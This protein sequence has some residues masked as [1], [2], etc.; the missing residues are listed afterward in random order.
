[1]FP[2]LKLDYF[3]NN[4]KKII[5]RVINSPIE[6][7]EAVLL[8][9]TDKLSTIR[10]KLEKNYKQ[11][12]F[13]NKF[14]ENDDTS[15]K[16][17]E[18]KSEFEEQFCLENIIDDKNILYIKYDIVTNID[19]SFFINKCQL[20]YG[21]TMTS[22]KIKKADKRAFEIKNSELKEI[23]S[24]GYE[25]N[26]IKFK[27][28]EERMKITNLIFTA[29]IDVDNFV[30]LGMSIGNKENKKSNSETSGSYYFIKHAKA[31]LKFNHN[32]TQE[33]IEEVETAIESE[34]PAEKLRQITDK[35]GQ[36][37]PTEVILGGRVY[38]DEQITSNR[39]L[40]ENS[41]EISVNAKAGVV[42]QTSVTNASNNSEGMSDYQESNYIELVGGEPVNSLF[43]EKDWV[44]SLKNYNYWDCIE[45]RSLISI[46]Q[47]LTYELRK[48]IITSV[49]KRIL[50]SAI[51]E[52]K[53][54]LETHG[55]AKNHVL[56]K[57]PQNILKMIHNKDAECNIFATVTDM[58]ELKKDLFTCQV[59]YPPN[60]KP[61]LLIHCI[62]EK[63]KKRECKLKIKWMVIGYY[64][65]FNLILSDLNVQSVKIF[66]N[67]ITSDNRTIIST[68]NF[69]YDPCDREVPPCFGIPV[70]TEK[71]SSN[72]SVVIGHHFFDAQEENKI[73]AC[74]FS[75]CSKNGRYICLPNFT[76]YTF[77]ISESCKNYTYYINSFEHP[78]ITRKKPY[79]N[80]NNDFTESSPK[81]ISLYSTQKTNYGP[82]FLK[83]NC[84]KIKLK[85]VN[86]KTNTIEQLKASK[87][88]IKCL[89][90]D[91]YISDN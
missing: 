42:L 76:F 35:F 62:Q 15:Y 10:E 29:D 64:T 52:L 8:N 78:F 26:K 32:P 85:F 4:D 75:Y 77:V 13:L 86:C 31:S 88:D 60:G 44:E 16:F 33:F 9:P 30:K 17:A 72:N 82:A 20:N 61:S 28:T 54:S 14:S 39:Y 49:G 3:G 43:N 12:N 66:E 41:R 89:C 1:M 25:K 74:M 18:I 36:F 34:D 70:L 50:Y 23:G 46:F 73:G 24:E 48:K 68:L 19:R 57:I 65:D 79:I 63:F 56:K 58:T 27:S 83:Q 53:Y 37:I 81:F 22:N 90:I 67:R 47:P 84:K 6:K 40:V 87:N 91:I 2:K 11:F 69:N 5:I 21:C 59:L 38:S 71:T 7:S 80:L 45:Y 55:T 51:E